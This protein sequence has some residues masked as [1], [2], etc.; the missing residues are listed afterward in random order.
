MA[1]YVKKHENEIVNSMPQ[2]RIEF[3]QNSSKPSKS[4]DKGVTGEK[5]MSSVSD[6]NS[7]KSHG[8]D[9]KPVEVIVAD[10]LLVMAKKFKND[11]IIDILVK[12]KIRDKVAAKKA[13]ERTI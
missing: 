10:P 11:E 6:H 7:L 4:G 2:N 5:L 9:T 13:E 12:W 1:F 3:E 8:K